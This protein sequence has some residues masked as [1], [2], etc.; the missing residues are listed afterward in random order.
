MDPALGQRVQL[1][2]HDRKIFQLFFPVRKR[3]MRYWIGIGG[4]FSSARIRNTAL[5]NIPEARSHA[6]PVPHAFRRTVSG[7]SKECS[8]AVMPMSIP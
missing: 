3:F 4:G 2:S 6:L 5:Q 7:P 8:W 1:K